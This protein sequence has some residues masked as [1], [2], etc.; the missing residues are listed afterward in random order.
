MTG[1]SKIPLIIIEIPGLDRSKPLLEILAKSNV[2]D[3][4][5]FPAV[6]FKSGDVNWRVDHEYLNTLYGRKITDGEIGCAISHNE[7]QRIVASSEKG[8]VILE[9]DARI[10]DLKMFEELAQRFLSN[11]P[12]NK[13]V[14]SLLPWVHLNVYNLDLT[15][16]KRVIF[17]LFG[18]TPLSV[19]YVVSKAAARELADSNKLIKYLPD[20]PKNSSY[21][22]TTVDG[23]ICHGDKNSKS[24]ID[25]EARIKVSRLRKI[26]FYSGLIYLRN[27]RLFG[28]PLNYLSLIH[29]SY[30]FWKLDNYIFSKKNLY[31]RLKGL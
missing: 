19:G 7:A 9:D 16:R 26:L 4:V 3:V 27:F 17:K 20:W 11:I 31:L 24:I 2:F 21:F 1:D 8:G 23:V 14:L 5:I 30:I 12:K 25:N 18:S 13:S 6:M 22:Y 28:N 15:V 10:Q 29:K